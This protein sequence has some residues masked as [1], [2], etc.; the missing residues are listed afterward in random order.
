M[1]LLTQTEFE[2]LQINESFSEYQN[3]ITEGIRYHLQNRLSIS[4]SIYRIGSESYLDFVNEMRRLYNEG[5]IVVCEEDQF[6]LEKLYTGKKGTWKNSD[7]GKKETVTLDDPQLL[8]DPKSGSLYHV[9]RPSPSGEK[10]KDT[11]LPKAIEMRFGQRTN[12]GDLDVRDKH[13]DPAK[14][15]AFL[16]RHNCKEKKDPYQ[17]GW[18]PCNMH[19]FY[20]QLGLKSADPW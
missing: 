4:E 8:K 14:R 11:G 16:A 7:T 18:W 3:S 1:R 15:S 20:K 5:K 13:Q 9:F 2:C 19:K 6:I 10:D 12:P 17:T